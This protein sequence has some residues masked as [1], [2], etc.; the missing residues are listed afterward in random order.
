MPSGVA[1]LKSRVLV[2]GFA[3]EV[4]SWSVSR[5]L[6]GDLPEQV[7]S[8][9]GITQAT[10]SV[11]WASEDTVT[12]GGLNPWNR[13]TGWIP[14]KGD[15]VEI[16][17]LDGAVERIQFTGVIDKST[18]DIGNGF[19]SDLIDDYD[20]LS[21]HITHEALLRLMPPLEH[22]GLYR[23]VGLLSTFYVDLAM[24]AGGFYC[25]PQQEPNAV[26]FAPCQGGMW[27]HSGTVLEAG[28]FDG[29]QRHAENRQAP[30]GF[31]ICNA[32]I[33][34]RVRYS[35]PSSTPLQITFMVGLDHAESASVGVHYDSG[36]E[37]RV[38][39]S[40][41]RSVAVHSIVGGV[42]VEVCRL[43]SSDMSGSTVVCAMLKSGIVTLRNSSGKVATGSFDGLAGNTSSVLVAARPEARIAGIQANHPTS[44]YLELRPSRFVPTAVINTNDVS[45]LGAMGACYAI[46]NVPAVDLLTEISQATLSGMWIDE[47]GVLQFVPSMVLR[48]KP[49]M[50][51]VTTLDDIFSLGW[52]DS[53]L[54]SRS[55]VTVA[56]KVPSITTSRY[57]NVELYRGSGAV[58]D[59]EET[60]E[61]IAEPAS[62]EAWVMPDESFTRVGT[63]NWPPYNARRGT[64]VG[65]YYSSDG[66]ATSETDLST[67]ITMEKLG[68][69]TYKFTHTAGAYPAGVEANLS[70]SPSHADLWENRRSQPLPLIGGGG[71]VQWSDSEVTPEGPFGVGPELRLEAGIWVA[72]VIAEN[73]ATFLQN[74][75]SS[76]KPTITGMEVSYDPARKLGDSLVIE[77][78]TLMGVFMK[79]LVVGIDNAASSDGFTQSLTVRVIGVT[80][81]YQTYAEFNA[82]G[83]ELSYQ[84]WQALGPVPETYSQFNESQGE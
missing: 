71:R 16:F 24:R 22:G 74:Q 60:I 82:S 27:P 65:V 64:F 19:Q 76:P 12:D 62:D 53:L 58:L 79:V 32:L 11:V 51:A 54:G 29:T 17:V 14:S 63:Y 8:A 13:S 39:A 7:V 6:N 46:D 56:V 35:E 43:P 28:S 2:N 83:G 21:A 48:N 1:A 36:S 49:A 18:G 31:A 70:T 69:N 72:P 45:H 25:T 30:W 34:Y 52:E 67:A 37:F 44:T 47:S 61:E 66:Q 73:I 75:T 68:V 59:S 20:R 57:Q 10:G 78:E 50:G 41:D 9:S 40:S 33:R 42:T 77:S 55:K 5:E 81:K 23:G 4:E 80:T 26:V 15:R 84:Q 3:R 38:T